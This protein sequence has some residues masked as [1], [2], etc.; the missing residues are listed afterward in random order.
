MLLLDVKQSLLNKFNKVTGKNVQLADVNFVNA[1][2]WLQNACNAKVTMQAKATSINFTG[3]VTL[4]YNRHRIDE[5]IPNVK[6]VGKPGTYRNTTDVLKMLRDV[7]QLSTYDED[8]YQETISPTATS[9]TI[10][11]RI[12][13]LAWLPPYPVTL[14]FE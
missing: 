8:F 11:P 2:V 5:F 9:I 1:G 3:A 12:D 4:F 7:Y 6:L 13:A 10:T 14:G